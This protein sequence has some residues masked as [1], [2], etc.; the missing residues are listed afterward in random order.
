MLT[1]PWFLHMV[2]AMLK[3]LV[4][5][6]WIVTVPQTLIFAHRLCHVTKVLFSCMDCCHANKTL[7]LH[8]VWTML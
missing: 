6:A 8:I 1:K 5:H 4:F 2:C 3:N 7:F